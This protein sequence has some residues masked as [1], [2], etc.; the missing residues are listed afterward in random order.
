MLL[1]LE[2]L[3]EG[4]IE[5]EGKVLKKQQVGDKLVDPSTADIRRVCS[6]VGM[7]FQHFNLF[8]HMT[9]LQNVMVGPRHG[10]GLT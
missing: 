7:V 9:V 10:K 2:I 5:I 8:S 4:A 3:D 6:K 1:W